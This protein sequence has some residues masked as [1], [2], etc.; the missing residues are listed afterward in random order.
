M[1][2]KKRPGT[3]TAQVVIRF[4]PSERRLLT[5]LA[6]QYDMTFSEFVRATL[7]GELRREG[8]IR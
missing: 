4:M 7:R 2:S 3:K 1:A 6:K 5:Q 8:L